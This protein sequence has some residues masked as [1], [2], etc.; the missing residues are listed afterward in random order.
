MCPP[1]R[2]AARALLAVLALAG[3]GAAP[4]APVPPPGPVALAPPPR[5]GTPVPPAPS[6]AIDLAGA[7]H[8]PAQSVAPS[9]EALHALFVDRLSEAGPNA[10]DG[11]VAQYDA[12]EWHGAAWVLDAA[13]PRFHARGTLAARGAPHPR[14]VAQASGGPVAAEISVAEWAVLVAGTPVLTRQ[15]DGTLRLLGPIHAAP[16]C[17]ACH[18]GQGGP[19]IGAFEYYFA[20]LADD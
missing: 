9:P 11:L 16:G 8:P 13:S 5:A 17:L 18:D 14:P 1:R 4:V 6:R 15:P 12:L 3:C 2:N 10:P 7:I 19:L 20:E